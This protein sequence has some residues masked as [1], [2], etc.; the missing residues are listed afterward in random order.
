MPNDPITELQRCIA[1]VRPS[2]MTDTA[3]K[4]WLAAAVAEVRHL[5]GPTLARAASQARKT[6][7]FPSEV[8]PAIIA[9]AA[10]VQKI[11]PAAQFA[12]DWDR[13][14][15]AYSRGY[16]ALEGPQRGPKRLGQVVQL[17]SAAQ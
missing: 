15:D 6:C 10:D 11:D 2:G 16:P 12:L 3:V 17:P 5:S 1:L 9:A 8:V 7:K 14:L 13:A 4:E